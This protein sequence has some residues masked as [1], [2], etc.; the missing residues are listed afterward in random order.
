MS[1]RSACLQCRKPN[2]SAST[3]R[4]PRR[5]NFG[6][7]WNCEA[8]LKAGKQGRIRIA[9]S[10]HVGTSHLDVLCHGKAAIV[11]DVVAYSINS[12]IR[13]W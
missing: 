12:A 9:L 8:P 2:V 13:H 10:L 1:I 5:A 6:T 11:N 3:P 4:A 7:H